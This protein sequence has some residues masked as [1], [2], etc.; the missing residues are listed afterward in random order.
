MIEEAQSVLGGGG[1][2]ESAYEEWVKEGRK[3]SLGAVLITQ[4]PGSI[5]SELLSQGDSWF[6][7]HLLSAG[8]LRAVKA[9]NAHFSDDLLSSLLNEPLPGTGVFWSSVAGEVD[10]AGNAYPIPVRVLSFEET[11]EM[12]DRDGSLKPIEGFAAQLASRSADRLQQARQRLREEQ[13]APS[14]SDGDSRE[15]ADEPGDVEPEEEEGELDRDEIY[16]RAAIQQLENDE[17]VSKFLGDHNNSITWRGVIEALKR[18]VPEDAVPDIGQWAYDL[19]PA[20]LDAVYGQGSWD[21]ERRPS[22]AD[23]AREVTWVVIQPR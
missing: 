15:G 2:G 19:V 6:L 23:P 8:D 16:R 14:S 9:A 13:P 17:E 18:G 21:S 3:Y 5:P 20:A 10:Q 22:K 7:F 12:R 1:S 11:Y 4:Q